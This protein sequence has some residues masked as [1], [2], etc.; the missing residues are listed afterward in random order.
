MTMVY[1]DP[2]SNTQS[3]TDYEK[4]TPESP[5][6]KCPMKCITPGNP[7]NMRSWRVAKTGR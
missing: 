5:T 7:S 3:D 6:R 2:Q 1:D 4:T